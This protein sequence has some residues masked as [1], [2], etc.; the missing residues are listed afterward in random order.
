MTVR[1]GARVVFVILF[2]LVTY[3]TVTPNP[4]DTKQGMAI[5]RWLSSLIFGEA[6]FADKIAHFGAY[7]VLSFSALAAGLSVFGAR[8]WTAV[9]L[10]LYGALLEGVQGVMGV[11]T[12]EFFDALSNAFGALCALPAMFIVQKLLR[13]DV[14]D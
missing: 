12:P 3:L 4:E 8:V 13:L 6:A 5:T 9:V 11:R 10:A 14:S 2:L 7:G 1:G